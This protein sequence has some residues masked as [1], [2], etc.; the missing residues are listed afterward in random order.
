MCVQVAWQVYANGVAGGKM[1][2]YLV[3]K[4]NAAVR[5][6]DNENWSGGYTI[7][8]RADSICTLF[9]VSTIGMCS[10]TRTRLR[11]WEE[12]DISEC[13]PP[14]DEASKGGGAEAGGEGA[15]AFF[16]NDLLEAPDLVF[17]QVR[18]EGR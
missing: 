18:W 16:P 1:E 13:E 12:F 6:E 5:N 10:Q 11:T 3:T 7:G 8:R 9:P 17:G 2:V 15:H 14:L 4:M